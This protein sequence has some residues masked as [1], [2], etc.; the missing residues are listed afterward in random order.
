MM[1]WNYIEVDSNKFTIMNLKYYTI[2]ILTI[3]LL[4]TSVLLGQSKVDQ[5][6][7]NLNVIEN[8]SD[9]IDT[10]NEIAWILRKKKGD[11]R[12]LYFANEAMSLA[13]TQKRNLRGLADSYV[14]LGVIY[15]YAAMY[16]S[17]IWYLKRSLPIRK[18]LKD[19]RGI[20]SVYLNLGNAYFKNHQPQIAIVRYNE[21]IKNAEQFE[22]NQSSFGKLYNALGI[23]YMELG[24][25]DSASFNINKSIDIRRRLGQNKLIPN[26]LIEL[27]NMYWR[28]GIY[29]NALATFHNALN[30]SFLVE[31]SLKVSKVYMNLGN[32]FLDLERFDSSEIY[33]SK[34]Y[35]INQELNREIGLGIYYNNISNLNIKRGLLDRSKISLAKALSIKT[36]L[37]DTMGLIETHNLF[38]NLYLKLQQPDS[39]AIY[40]QK[41]YLLLNENKTPM[42]ALEL[43]PKMAEAY[44]LVGNHKQAAEI[45][46]K[47]SVLVNKLKE[48]SLR[49][50]DIQ[51]ALEK[52]RTTNAIREK[53]IQELKTKSTFIQAG[54][55]ITILA[56][57]CLVFALRYNFQKRKRLVAESETFRA[58]HQKQIAENNERLSQQKITDLLNEIELRSNYAQMEGELNE[59]KRIAKDLHDRVGSMLTTVNLMLSAFKKDL[60]DLPSKKKEQ[61]AD[62]NKVLVEA[63]EEV[64]RI[65][66]NLHAGK[67]EESGLVRQVEEMAKRIQATELIKVNL[68]THKMTK[69]LELK[70]EIVIYRIIQELVGNVLKHAKA[71]NLT[72]QINRLKSTLN[73]IVEDDGQGFNRQKLIENQSGIGL[74]NVFKRVQG[75]NG[76]VTV[77]SGKGAGTTVLVDL[78]ISNSKI[79]EKTAEVI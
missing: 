27:G 41:S 52:E 2:L 29:Q 40:F 36:V 39:A 68:N 46:T 66:H 49:A 5:M 15:H 44:R 53:E 13:K 48:S 20:A 3:K 50:I 59:R 38:G 19:G 71:K 54:F 58:Y 60:P 6:I 18:E 1:K 61:F 70:K 73:I 72:I 56:G 31:D 33:Y 75:L 9:R 63:N 76:K 24:L 55:A 51:F 25:L 37:N 74:N 77:D 65:S 32:V 10:L 79:E 7:K 30:Y 17:A 62:A 69:R 67:I 45:L 28:Q 12:A 42:L 23:V 57:I 16:D 47:Q 34:S 26:S 11:T 78:P 21:G 64:R 14:R 22:V 4:I 43:Y 35:E 8:K